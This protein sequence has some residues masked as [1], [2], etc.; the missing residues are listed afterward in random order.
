MDPEK[1]LRIEAIIRRA[2]NR[3]D[4]AAAI[5]EEIHTAQAQRAQSLR[6]GDRR[7]LRVRH[8]AQGF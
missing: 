1:Q 3:L 6:L 7:G 2:Q 5:I 4:K 8:A